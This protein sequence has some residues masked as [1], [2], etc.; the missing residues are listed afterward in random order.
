MGRIN[1]RSELSIY[2]VL[3]VAKYS[4]ANVNILSQPHEVKIQFQ[5]LV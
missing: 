3:E 4:F 5:H 2:V 1:Q